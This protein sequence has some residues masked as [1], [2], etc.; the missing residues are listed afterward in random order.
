LVATIA[1]SPPEL[2]PELPNSEDIV[3]KDYSL[4]LRP[5][6]ELAL[7]DNF[8]PVKK[9]SYRL[10]RQDHASPLIFIIAGTIAHNA[11]SI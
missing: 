9:L 8:W 10:A 1:T 4:I 5:E 6:R 2:R 11:S 7:P 3:Q